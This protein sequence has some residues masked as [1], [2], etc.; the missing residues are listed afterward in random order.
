MNF[1]SDPKVN[2]A[3]LKKLQVE[4]KDGLEASQLFDPLLG[5]GLTYNDFLILPGHIDFAAS[6]VDLSVNITKRIR[7]KTPFLSSPMDTVTES[8]MAIHIALS[9]GIGVIHH[10]CSVQEQAAMVRK[11]KTFENGFIS[12]PLCLAPENTIK[13]LHNI[14]EKFGYSGIPITADG[15]LGSKLLGLVTSRDIDFYQSLIFVTR[16]RR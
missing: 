11:V 3:L 10:N 9:G 2:E 6:Q 5:G 4:A 7:I 12:S 15:K 14:K 1:S 16:C 8:E 13:D